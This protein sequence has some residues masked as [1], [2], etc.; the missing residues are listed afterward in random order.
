[1]FGY[2]CVPYAPHG[3][4]VRLE[5]SNIVHVGLPIFNVAGMVPSYHPIVVV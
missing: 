1:M 5:H 2:C 3:L 4:L